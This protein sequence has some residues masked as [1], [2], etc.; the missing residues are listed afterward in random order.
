MVLK[1]SFTTSLGQ[2]GEF[3]LPE[4]VRH[5][6]GVE[7]GDLLIVSV[8]DGTLHVESAN[9]ILRRAQGMFKDIAPGRSMVDELIAERREEAR[10]EAEEE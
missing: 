9:E 3:V 8:K 6:L 7:P 5:E 10:R 4:D 2:H 1:E